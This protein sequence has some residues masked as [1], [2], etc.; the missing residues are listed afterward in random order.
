MSSTKGFFK[1]IIPFLAAFSLGIFIASFFVTIGGPRF[2]RGGMRHREMRELR[3]EVERLRMENIQL[4][5][6]VKELRSGGSNWSRTDIPVI[7]DDGVT[8]EAPLPL[9]PIPGAPHNHR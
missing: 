1:R 6:Q 2:R 8:F 5:D 4:K 3:V 9:P 7:S